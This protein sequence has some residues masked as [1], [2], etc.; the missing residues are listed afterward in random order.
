[1]SLTGEALQSR[2]D[3]T[4]ATEVAIA[5]CTLTRMLMFRSAEL[6]PYR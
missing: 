6:Y 5:A 4:E 1:M 3:R 2:A